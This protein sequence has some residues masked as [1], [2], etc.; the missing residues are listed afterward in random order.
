GILAIFFRAFSLGGGTY[1]G[2]EAVSNGLQIMREPKVRTGKKTMVYMAVSLAITAGG[3]LLLY[4]LYNVNPVEGRTLNAVLA[5]AVFG[6]WGWGHWI[7][8]ITILSE[9]ALLFVG[10]QT[11]FT[12]GPGV[13]ANMAVDSWFPKRFSSLSERLTMQNGVL[14]MG[15]SALLLL[16]YTNGSVSAL[17]VMYAINVF[18][19][20][21]L[22]QVGMIR[23]FLTH[24][25]RYAHWKK[26]II[27]FTVGILVC[28]VILVITIYEKFWEGG[29]LTL[30]ITSCVIAMC[31][32]V[33]SH[34]QKVKRAI[35]SLDTALLNIRKQD[36][37]NTKEV[38][39]KEKT[40]VLLVHDYNGFGVI[41]MFSILKNFQGLYKNI[42]FVSVA[43]INSG[44]FK[45]QHEIENL[46]E[47]T[48]RSLEKYVKLARGV[49]IPAD[50]RMDIGTDVV[51]TA[52]HLCS[53]LAIKF[54]RVTFF[55]GKPI[56]EH[57][58]MIHKMLHNETPVAIQR[59]LQWL[60]I[61]TVIIPI[62][63][64]L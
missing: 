25:K 37:P 4:V 18:L 50:Y 14:L 35:D 57:E 20:F 62:K 24:K 51:D 33:H 13:M 47:D 49:G 28:L 29:W 45:G 26:N 32:V 64:H 54:K 19:T 60:G 36:F 42:I 3:L 61:H 63:V 43:E 1:T 53:S 8:L 5:N 52:S 31:Y 27:I 11:G 22:S 10:A 6:S 2:L 23:F 46:K 30:L 58:G 17:V 15:I 56:F 34:Y 44:V 21:L 7:A 38:D 40:A 9:G 41:T 39:P 16:V 12:G 55:A 59:R 48:K